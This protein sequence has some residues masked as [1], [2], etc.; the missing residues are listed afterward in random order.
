MP[1]LS[2]SE[3]RKRPR[4]RRPR[5]VTIPGPPMTLGDMRQHGVRRL[6][7]HCESFYCLH[8]SIIAVE[9]FPDNVLVPSLGPRMAC[10]QCGRIGAHARPYWAEMDA[11]GAGA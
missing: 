9:N 2:E 4:A 8:S 10:T 1:E 5:N 3:Q 11:K 6:S 7:V